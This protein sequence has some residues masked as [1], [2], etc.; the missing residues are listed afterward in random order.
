MCSN[1]MA[2][3][4]VIFKHIRQRLRVA[5]SLEVKWYPTIQELFASSFHHLILVRTYI[6]QFYIGMHYFSILVNM[7]IL[8]WGK[9]I[10]KTSSYMVETS[11]QTSRQES[12]Q[13]NRQEK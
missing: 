11:V 4:H 1:S 10:L 13:A 3:A 6:L 7:T 5:V 12:K 9:R 2:S 8:F